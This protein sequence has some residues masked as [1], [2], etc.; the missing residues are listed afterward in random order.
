MKQSVKKKINNFFLIFLSGFLIS[1]AGNYHLSSMHGKS[2]LVVN[3]VQLDRFNSYLKGEFYSYELK[4]KVSHNPIMFAISADGTTSLIFSCVS[5]STECNPGV[6]IY[7]LI[8]RYSKKS[9]KE[10]FIFALKNK[11]VWADSN[12]L[13]KGYKLNEQNELLK[14]VHFNLKDRN[15]ANIKFYD[16][17]ILPIDDDDFEN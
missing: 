6:S 17:S 7:Q 14:N 12:Y 3:K 9:N 2:Q 10:M 16:F 1:C 8:K 5:R 11:I 15:S 4:R 13:V